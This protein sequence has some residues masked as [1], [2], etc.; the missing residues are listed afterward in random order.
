MIQVGKWPS[1]MRTNIPTVFSLGESVTFKKHEEHTSEKNE[2]WPQ[3]I[4]YKMIKYEKE[5]QNEKR[6]KT[7]TK[8]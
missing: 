8:L 2:K 4:K 5:I 1:R 3:K 7:N 6:R